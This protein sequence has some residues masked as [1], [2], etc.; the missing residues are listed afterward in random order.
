MGALANRMQGQPGAEHEDRRAVKDAE[1]LK[2]GG[3]RDHTAQGEVP[4]ARA[5][6]GRQTLTHLETETLT[7]PLVTKCMHPPTC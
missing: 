6:D 1:E 4:D 5:G 2:P 7:S 3:R